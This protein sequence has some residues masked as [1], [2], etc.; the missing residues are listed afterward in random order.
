MDSWHHYAV[1]RASGVI[2]R[3]IDGIQDPNTWSSQTTF[4][5]DLVLGSEV[6]NNPNATYSELWCD[7]LIDH[8]EIGNI[9]LTQTEIQPYMLVPKN[10]NESGFTV[11]WNV[12]TVRWVGAISSTDAASI[13][14]SGWHVCE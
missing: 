13:C 9:S 14:D 10:G 6:Y 11:S 7:G 5:G 8:F 2:T 1:V 4:V 3:Y 12:Q